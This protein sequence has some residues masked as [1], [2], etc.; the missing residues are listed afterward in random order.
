VSSSSRVWPGEYLATVGVFDGLHLGHR[1]ILDRLLTAS[2][3]TGLPAVLFTFQ[4]RPVTVFAPGTPHDELT[5]LPR[6]LRL[7]AELGIQRVSVLRFSAAFARIEA[8]SFLTEILGAGSGLRGLWIGHDFRFGHR[9]RGDWDLVRREADRLGFRA[10]RAEA[11]LQGT[12]PVSSSRIREYLRAGEIES[13]A[14]L[15]GR[16]PD[17]EGT[18]VT[19]RGQG[20]RVLVATANLALPEQQCLPATGVYAGE[21]EWEG[22]YRPAVMNLG[23]RPTLTSEA[24]VVPEVHILDTDEDLR[25]QRL[26]FRIRARLREERKFP[27]ID[28]LRTQVDADI[29][30]ARRLAAEWKPLETELAPGSE[31]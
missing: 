11:L 2:H 15:L 7:I 1:A 30:K 9:R 18:V 20:R 8:E 6:K 31:A 28:E 17:L 26:L 16:W 23:R 29:E 12:R 5:P 21:A 14:A 22:S 19:G 27:S 10:E 13:A 24:E 3:E 25:G 4:P